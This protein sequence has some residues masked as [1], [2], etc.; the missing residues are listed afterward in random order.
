MGGQY[1]NAGGV[2]EQYDNAGGGGVGGNMTMPGGAWGGNMTMP[3][4]KN[5]KYCILF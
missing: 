1:Y 5:C 3:F 2:G 4:F